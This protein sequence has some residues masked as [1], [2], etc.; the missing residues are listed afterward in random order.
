MVL[1]IEISLNQAKK[2]VLDNVIQSFKKSNIV[3][4]YFSQP[5]ILT[6]KN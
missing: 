6:T 2:K 4:Q 1:P 5:N 3:V